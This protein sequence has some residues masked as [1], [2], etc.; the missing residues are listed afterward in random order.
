MLE[1]SVSLC[2]LAMADFEEILPPET[3]SPIAQVNKDSVSSDRS[4][5]GGGSVRQVRKKF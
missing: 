5:G 3:F 1:I 2:F 4:S